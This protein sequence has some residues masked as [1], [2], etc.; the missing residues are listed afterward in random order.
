MDTQPVSAAPGEVSIERPALYVVATPIGNLGDFSPRAVAVLAAVD[1][2]FCEDTRHSRRLLDHYGI[3]T[4]LEPLH[5]HNERRMA[6]QL[7][8]RMRD[9]G[10][11]CAL[12]SD[13][14]TPLISDPGYV[15]VS[16]ALDA[17][18]AVRT[19]PGPSALVAALSIS[20]L[21]TDRFVF[22]G[23][24]PSAGGARARRLA[25]LTDEPRTLVF[26]EAPHRLL[27]ML[28]D[29]REAFGANRVAVVTREL[30]KRFETVYRGTLETL[31]GTLG[32][33]PHATR[34]EI[35]VL[36][37][38]A[39]QVA[40]DAQEAEIDRLLGVLLAETDQRTAV[41][42]VTRLTGARRN[43]VYR[44]ALALAADD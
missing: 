4:A 12:V 17:G 43:A 21:P 15:L 8:A 24:L 9:A 35:V 36:V 31:L 23:F 34:G 33:D 1:R 41:R 13:A 39:P 29:L 25:A 37:A 19:V 20:G 22:E 26:Y 28:T 7:V 18:V 5:A 42:V 2:I 16:S 27:A 38:G 44:R 30:S 6:G 11:A 10:E 32:A 14:G 40:T 3:T